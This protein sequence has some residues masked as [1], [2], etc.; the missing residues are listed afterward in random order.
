MSSNYRFFDYTGFMGKKIQLKQPRVVEPYYYIE[1]RFKNSGIY[2]KTPKICVPFG[3]NTF[4]ADNGDRSYSYSLSLSDADIDPNIERFYVFL[5]K[6]EAFCQTAVK[7]NLASWGHPAEF[8]QLT[9][10]S[11]FRLLDETRTPLFRLKI[12]QTGRYPTELYDELGTLQTGLD[13]EG[14]L[15]QFVM[16]QCQVISLIEPAS[17]WL[18][19]DTEEY[20]LTWRVHQMRVYPCTRPIGGVSLLDEQITVH[21]IRI[22][23]KE[24]V[25]EVNPT[26]VRRPAP[27]MIHRTLSCTP[28]RGGQGSQGRGGSVNEPR[29]GPKIPRGGVAMLPFLSSISSGDFKLKKVD[30][31]TDQHSNK[32]QPAFSLAEILQI[33]NNLKKQTPKTDDPAL[34]LSQI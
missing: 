29:G 34:D 11:G 12:S 23:E 9:F 26:P 22:V 30:V 1:L 28:Y 10:K 15:E 17:I 20:G 7:A 24:R 18:N 27:P 32:G 19:T 33:R 14:Q 16:D 25:I 21:T 2:I 13:A 8:D 31:D 4:V 5:R 6:I 3:L